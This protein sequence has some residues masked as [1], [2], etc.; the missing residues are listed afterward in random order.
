[1][2]VREA[3]GDAT[4]TVTNIIAQDPEVAGLTFALVSG[5]LGTFAFA[6]QRGTEPPAGGGRSSDGTRSPMPWRHGG[7]MSGPLGW[8]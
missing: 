3:T 8:T 6:A 4:L 5:V 1:M 2:A 7:A